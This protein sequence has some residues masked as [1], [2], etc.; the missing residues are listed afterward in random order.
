MKTISTAYGH[1]S[2]PNE[3]FRRKDKLV[4][5][6]WDSNLYVIFINKYLCNFLS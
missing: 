4:L 6:V 2:N 3:F 5:A 1:L